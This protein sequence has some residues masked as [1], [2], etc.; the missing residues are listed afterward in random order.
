MSA[1]PLTRPH[2]GR[3]AYLVT[4]GGVFRESV[5]GLIPSEWFRGLE[6]VVDALEHEGVRY[7]LEEEA[8]N[9]VRIYWG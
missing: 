1:N 2:Q 7:V 3:G 9:R 8:P 6:E 4:A 5:H